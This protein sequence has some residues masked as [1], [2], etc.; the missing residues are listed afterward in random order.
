MPSE[1][2]ALS[3]LAVSIQISQVLLKSK[4][5]EK[6]MILAKKSVVT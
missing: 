5:H 2:A 6:K 4:S 3:G 1:K